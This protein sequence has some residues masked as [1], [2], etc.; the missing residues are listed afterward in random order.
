MIQFGVLAVEKRQSDANVTNENIYQPRA[1]HQE[2][3]RQ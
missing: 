1:T 3:M 2:D